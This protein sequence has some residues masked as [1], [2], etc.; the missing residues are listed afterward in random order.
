MILFQVIWNIFSRIPFNRTAD[1]EEFAGRVFWLVFVA[2]LIYFPPRIFYLAEDFRRPAAWL[3]MLLAN[4]PV[5]LRALF[6]GDSN[7]RG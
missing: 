4:S 5:I 3:T 7:V 6:G 2:M 1:V